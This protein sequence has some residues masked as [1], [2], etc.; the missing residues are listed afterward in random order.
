V[1][2]LFRWLKGHLNIRRFAYKNMNAIKILLAVAVIVQ[3]LVRFKM[4]KDAFKGTNWDYLRFVRN[5][6]DRYLYQK[7]TQS[8]FGSGIF[9][10]TFPTAEIPI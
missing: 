4:L 6:L 2:L 8:D 1:E 3:L 5:S 7:L 10:N 9:M